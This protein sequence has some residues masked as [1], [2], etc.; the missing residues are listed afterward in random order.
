MTP[1]DP[2]LS[3]LIAPLREQTIGAIL[4]AMARAL[5]ADAD[6]IPEPEL[7]DADG[8]VARSGPLNLPRRGDLAV[9]SRG[10]TLIRR[11]ESGPVSGANALV[12]R[13]SGGFEA[14]ITAFRWEAADLTV[15]AG[16]ER[17]D[18]GPLRRWFLEWFQTRYSEV[19]PDLYGAVHSLDGPRRVPGGWGFTADFGSAPVACIV[20]LIAAVADS[21]ANRM[22]IAQA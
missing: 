8:R 1:P 5:E 17:P 13:T 6:V 3:R 11:I 12:V 16:G 10:R 15:F 2:A 20:A 19:A 22:R 4:E 14:E 7:R 21:G 18:W 9:T